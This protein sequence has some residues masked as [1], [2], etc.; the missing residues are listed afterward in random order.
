MRTVLSSIGVYADVP[1]TSGSL[2]PGTYA[3]SLTVVRFAASG[4]STP[5]FICA[6]SSA[7]TLVV[8][9]P[10]S[11]LRPLNR[12]R[13]TYKSAPTTSSITTKN[14]GF[15]LPDMEGGGEED[16]GG[17]RGRGKSPYCLSETVPSVLL[18]LATGAV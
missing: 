18:V 6:S 13:P 4:A 10:P 16:T 14:A 2:V 11:R 8:S 12:E 17:M 9:P 7:E 3:Y 1:F 15:G 5:P